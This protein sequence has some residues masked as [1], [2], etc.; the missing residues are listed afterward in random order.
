MAPKHIAILGGGIASLTAAYELTQDPGWKKRYRITVYQQGWRLGG[1]GASGRNPEQHDRIEEHGLHV[2]FGFYE[3]AFRLIRDCYE[4]YAKLGKGQRF[5]QWRDA[6][7]P[8]DYIVLQESVDS[9]SGRDWTPWPLEFPMDE[10]EGTPGDGRPPPTP[11]QLMHRMVGW[12][13]ENFLESEFGVALPLEKFVEELPPPLA[14][15]AFV[16]RLREDPLHAGQF[17]QKM[18]AL[19]GPDPRAGYLHVASAL[20]R[21]DDEEPIAPGQPENVRWLLGHHQDWMEQRTGEKALTDEWRRL[22]ILGDLVKSAVRGMVSEKLFLSDADFEAL[23][24]VDFRAWLLQHGAR[25]ETANSA[26]INALYDLIFSSHAE[27]AAGS[28]LLR[29]LRMLL[30]YK[31]AVFYK[32]QA[33]MGDT[34]FSPLYEVLKAR[35]VEFAFFHRVKRLLSDDGRSITGIEMVRQM[36]VKA[37]KHDYQPLIDV[38]GV[39][40]WPNA[41][42]YAQLERGEELKASRANLEDFEPGFED[43]EHL[44]LRLG[45]GRDFDLVVLGIPVGAMKTLCKPLFEHHPG[46][47]QMI[48]GVPTVATLAMQLWLQPTL[49]GLGWKKKSPVMTSYTKPFDTWADMPQTLEAESWPQPPMEAPGSVAYFCGPFPDA[50]EDRPVADATVRKHALAWLP[51][52]IPG[53]WPQMSTDA[54]WTQFHAPASSRGE[55]RLD[56]QYLRANVQPSDRYVLCPPGSTRY[57]P[58]AGDSGFD[59]LVLTGDWLRTTLNGGFVE[60]AVMSGMQASRVVSGFPRAIIGERPR[61]TPLATARPS[62]NSHPRADSGAPAF[63]SRGGDITQRG[64]YELRD[65]RIY[66]FTLSCDYD[67]LVRL[68]DTCLNLPEAASSGV[69]Y[70]PLAPFVVL[71]FAKMDSARS[72]HAEDRKKGWTHERDVSVWIPVLARGG[73][74]TRLVWFLPYV[75]VDNPE[76]VALGREVYGY[77]KQ[78]ATMHFPEEHEPAEFWVK[79]NVFTRYREDQQTTEEKVMRVS[80]KAPMTLSQSLASPVDDLVSGLMALAASVWES[81]TKGMSAADASEAR[82]LFNLFPSPKARM[83]FLKQIRDVEDTSRACYKALVEAPLPVRALRGLGRIKGDFRAELASFDSHPMLKELG[84]QAGPQPVRLAWWCDCDFDVEAGQVL[85]SWPPR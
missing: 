62:A 64:P 65:V 81:Q 9:P 78:Q 8:H 10:P 47:E 75:F 63:L 48:G 43:A 18:Q 38:K 73:G 35:G 83:V 29:T 13:A 71:Q 61:R 11:W 46:L 40:C 17:N 59:N 1:K 41:P 51:Q 39:Q 31:G 32:M 66:S 16:T 37:G 60:A 28:G 45:E 19:L 7:E 12:L 6:F 33:G 34:V 69:T 50:P 24:D 58:E 14:L 84:L 26:A 52:N 36:K 55:Q 82:A 3:N 67:A 76:A 53:L 5:K 21:G 85:W 23:D 20:L 57:R 25:P 80:P 49:Q 22:K 2:W 70:R 77:P 44:T 74:S 72:G 15:N 27:V 4:H 54:L 42:D 79:T 30:A 68:C 56:A